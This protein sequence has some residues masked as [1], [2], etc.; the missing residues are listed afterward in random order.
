MTSPRDASEPLRWLAFAVG[1]LHDAETLLLVP[2]SAPSGTCVLA[3]QA[4]E[5]A[6]KALLARSGVRVPRTHDLIELRA[7]VSPEIV[8]ELTDLQLSWL[9]GWQV[10]GRYPGDWPEAVMMDANAAVALAR[11]I[12]HE[13]AQRLEADGDLE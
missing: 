7:S 10:R 6:L 5:K 12:I 8:S 11:A 4:A 2:D 13:A 1:D 9:S 3:Q